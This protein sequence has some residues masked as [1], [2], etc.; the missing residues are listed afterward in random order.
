MHDP[1]EPL[2]SSQRGGVLLMRTWSDGEAMMIRQLLSSYGIACQVVSDVSHTVLP[3][4]IDGL[5]EVRILVSGR[6]LVEARGLL[7]EHRRHGLRLIQGGRATIRAARGSGDAQ[8]LA[9]AERDGG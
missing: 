4:A 6:C 2:D 8:R 7:A 9:G 3:I 5:G 1:R